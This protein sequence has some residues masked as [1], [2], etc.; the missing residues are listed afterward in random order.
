MKSIPNL[1]DY[2]IELLQILSNTK[3]VELLKESLRKLFLDILKNYSYMSL[4][5]FKIVLTESLKFSAWYQDPDAI[6]ETLSI[7]Q[8]KC[9]LYLWKCADQKWYLDDLYD[10]INEI[11]EQ[12]LARIPIF[13]LIPENPR[14]VKI[15]LESGLMVFKPEMFPVFSKIEPNDLNEVLTW[16]DR[17]LL[18][19]TK[20]E[21]LKIYSLEEWGGLVGRENFYR[22]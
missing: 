14:E 5:E 19:G 17:F 12:I 6:T 13:H 18:V 1:Q 21:N 8:G 2:K 20:V 11:T 22:G 10:D 7:H 15:L 3:D 16:D 9:D 4:P